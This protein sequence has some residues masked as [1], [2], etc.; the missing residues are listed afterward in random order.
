MELYDVPD[1][2][3]PVEKLILDGEIVGRYRT[4]K[5][6]CDDLGV[7]YTAMIGYACRGYYSTNNVNTAYGFKWRFIEDDIVQAE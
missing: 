4:I 1:S 5:E 2:S 3:K 6:A 7:K